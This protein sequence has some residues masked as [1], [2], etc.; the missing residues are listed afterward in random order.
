MGHIFNLVILDHKPNWGMDICSVKE[1]TAEKTLFDQ[2][3]D[4]HRIMLAHNVLQHSAFLG[5]AED[6]QT[7]SSLS[8]IIN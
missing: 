5:F 1:N 8:P 6:L 3:A 2:K 4:T 7:H